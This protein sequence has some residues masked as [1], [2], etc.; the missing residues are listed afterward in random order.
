MVYPYFPF[1]EMVDDDPSAV[2]LRPA[3]FFF[4]QMDAEFHGFPVKMI[5]YGV[6][7]NIGI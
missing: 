3:R 5:S 4:Q 2:H 7:Y 1:D 6:T